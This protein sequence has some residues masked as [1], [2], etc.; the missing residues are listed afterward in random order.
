MFIPILLA[1]LVYGVPGGLLFALASG[2]AICPFLP[3]HPPSTVEIELSSWLCQ[4]AAFLLTGCLSGLASDAMRENLSRFLQ[5]TRL[6]PATGLPNARALLTAL[7]KLARS[8]RRDASHLLGVVTV[9]NSDEMSSAFGY[10]VMDDSMQKLAACA[11][12]CLPRGATVFRIGSE[13]IGFLSQTAEDAM[14]PLLARLNAAF[15]QPLMHL[16]QPIHADTRIGYVAIPGF[17]EEPESYLRKAQAASLQASQSGHDISLYRSGIRTRARDNLTI[18]GELI[19]GME[20]EEIYLH[21]QP[22]VSL[23][24][25]AVTGVEALIRWQHPQRG[26]LPP[27]AFITRAEQSTL[28]HALTEFVLERAL[29][30]AVAW[31][32]AGMPVP[33]AVNVSPRNL[34]QPGFCSTVQRAM[35]RCGASSDLLELEVTEGAMVGDVDLVAAELRQLSDLGVRIAIDDFGTGYSSLN[36]LDRLPASVLKI[37]QSFIRRMLT[38]TSSIDIVD[39]VVSVAHKKGVH[40]VAEGV[41]SQAVFDILR[42]LGCDVAQGYAIGKPMPAAEFENWYR[43]W[44]RGDHALSVKSNVLEN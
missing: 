8:R 32:D 29:W 37:D 5:Q 14:L 36:Y 18:L 13:Q 6:D 16:A 17:L 20:R 11:A 42:Q 21:Y 33:I 9:Y 2:V 26:P 38:E 44:Q 1:A 15:R 19:G 22:K 25:G 31:R 41:E 23:I 40:I 39:A 35:A 12:G 10:G 24:T 28:I 43:A 27:A 7:E 4:V 3:F 34:M 30:Q